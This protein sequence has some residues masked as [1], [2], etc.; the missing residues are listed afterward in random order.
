MKILPTK[1]WHA[2]VRWIDRFESAR[3]AISPARLS[4]V[5]YSWPLRTRVCPCDA[6][7]CDFLRDR[8]IRMKNVF[9]LGSGGHHLVG[10]RNLSDGLDNDVLAITLAPAELTSYVDRVVRDAALARHYKVLFADI[11]SLHAAALPV[12]DVVTLFHLGEFGDET[13]A[14]WR[15]DDAAVLALFIT[16]LA[17]RGLLLFYPGSFAYAKVSP[18]IEQ[19]VN[20]RQIEFVENVRSLAVYRRVAD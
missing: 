8:R 2:R 5:H 10:E 4:F 7:F 18:W 1:W 6:N 11:H 13:S 12:F 16:R 17:P 14:A 9:H 3:R 20:R 19:A 15:L